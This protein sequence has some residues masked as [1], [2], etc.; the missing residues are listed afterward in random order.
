MGDDPGQSLH[1][2]LSERESVGTARLHE[3]VAALRAAVEKR[4]RERLPLDWAKTQ[5]NIGIVLTRLGERESGRARLDEAVAAFNSCLTVI[6]TA[7]PGEWVHQ[8]RSH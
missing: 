2:A 1:R 8:V 5:N 6:E 7:W 3:A 4:T